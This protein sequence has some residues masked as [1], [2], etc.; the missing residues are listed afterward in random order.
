MKLFKASLFAVVAAF[1]LNVAAQEPAGEKK[2]EEKM[3][4]MEKKQHKME[5]K[6]RKMNKKMDRMDKTQKTDEKKMDKMED[7]Q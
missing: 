6:Q 1:S 2:P 4:N 5:K 3:E 7:K